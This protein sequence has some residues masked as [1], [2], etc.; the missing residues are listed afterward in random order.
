M[1][2]ASQAVMAL[3]AALDQYAEAQ[4]AL[5]ALRQYYGSDEWRHDFAD[6]QIRP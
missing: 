6:E 2:R 5:A 4:E 3:S 1:E